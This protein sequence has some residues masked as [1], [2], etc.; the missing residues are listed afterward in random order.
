MRNTNKDL[1]GRVKKE[2]EWAQG[3]PPTVKNLHNPTGA[4]SR[5]SSNS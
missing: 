4:T 5:K 1:K 2:T 3:F